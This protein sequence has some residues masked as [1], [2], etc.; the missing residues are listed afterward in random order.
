MITTTMATLILTVLVLFLRGDK[1]HNYLVV[2]SENIL[3]GG[4]FETSQEH[5]KKLPD[6]SLDF[7]DLFAKRDNCLICIEVE[8]SARR[9]LIN[10]A[11]AEQLRLPLI[12]IVPT[13]K[14]KKSVQNK[15]GKSTIKPAGCD[16]YIL[17]LSQLEQ[18]LTNCFPLFSAANEGRK[19]IKTNN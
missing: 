8:T 1:L 3:Q 9:V 11:K 17:L 6:G 5:P 15:L 10:A 19:N 16:I 14:I 12:V 7:I 4:G 18:E 13:R 2:E